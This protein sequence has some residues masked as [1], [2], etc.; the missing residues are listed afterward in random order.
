MSE[1]HGLITGYR[2]AGGGNQ[3]IPLAPESLSI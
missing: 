1:V 2:M 3:K